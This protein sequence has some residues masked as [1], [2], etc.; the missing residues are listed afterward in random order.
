[1]DF[2]S[3]LILTIITS[4]LTFF[5]INIQKY[6]LSYNIRHISKSRKLLQFSFIIGIIKTNGHLQEGY[7]EELPT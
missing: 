3:K 5:D 7:H 1:M 4:I 2:S 6:I